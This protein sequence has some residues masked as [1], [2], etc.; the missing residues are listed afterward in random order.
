[1]IAASAVLRDNKDP[2]VD[3]QSDGFG[4]EF[5]EGKGWRPKEGVSIRAEYV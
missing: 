5:R 3:R 2:V 1:V 4:G